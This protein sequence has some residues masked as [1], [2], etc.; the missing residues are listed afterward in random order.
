MDKQID[1]LPIKETLDTKTN[2]NEG[3]LFIA[4]AHLESVDKDLVIGRRVP[5]DLIIGTVGG[6][7]RPEYE[8][9]NKG[10]WAPHLDLTALVIKDSND[11]MIN[12]PMGSYKLS[13][14]DWHSLNVLSTHTAIELDY[15]ARQHISPIDLWPEFGCGS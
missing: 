11:G 2:K 7:G 3:W 8:A 10:T 5:G 6:T 15:S 13:S 4:Y 9:Y 14:T 12:D 1:H